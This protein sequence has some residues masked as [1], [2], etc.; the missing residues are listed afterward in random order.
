MPLPTSPKTVRPV[1]QLLSHNVEAINA[2]LVFASNPAHTTAA[3]AAELRHA[4]RNHM[5]LTGTFAGEHMSDEQL[6]QEHIASLSAY[7]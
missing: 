5:A 4:Y 6:V 3:R 7:A 2:C 1:D